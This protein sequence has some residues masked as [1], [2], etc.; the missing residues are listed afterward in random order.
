MPFCS[1]QGSF[2][3]LR[4]DDSARYGSR[5]GS[6]RDLANRSSGL[7]SPRLVLVQPGSA[8]LATRVSAHFGS[9]IR[10]DL[11][12]RI[13]A[14]ESTRWLSSERGWGLVRGL[15]R[16]S[17][18]RIWLGLTRGFAR[19]IWIRARLGSSRLGSSRFANYYQANNAQT[20]A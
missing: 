12:L 15:T 18:L 2:L 11:G 16:C 20:N 7:G 4:L 1:V 14:P 9:G 17:R 8:R 10:L 5:S 19:H 3:G 13:W 6:A